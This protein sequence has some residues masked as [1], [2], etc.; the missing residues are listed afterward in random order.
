MR[1]TTLTGLDYNLFYK[2]LLNGINYIFDTACSRI[3]LY[4]KYLEFQGWFR[5]TYGAIPLDVEFKMWLEEG[6]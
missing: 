3:D 6:K 4:D 2:S 5:N 1:K